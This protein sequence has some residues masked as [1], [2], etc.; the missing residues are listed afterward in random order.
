[1]YL[2]QTVAPINE[3]VSL[4]EAK[5]FMRILEN[6]DDTLIE[7]M[8]IGAR[9]YAE[10]YTNRQLMTAT[11]ELYLSDFIQDFKMPKNPIQSI[12]SIEYMDEDGNY[13]VLDSSLYY[14]YGDNDISKIHFEDFEDHKEHKKAIKITFVAGYTTVPSSI[15][16]YI[17]VLVSTMYE[18]R[19]QYIIGVSAETNANPMINK[20][21]DMYRVQPI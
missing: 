13:Q 7:S 9:E 17:K 5:K 8:I 18:N 2:V 14:L 10:N 19:E 20:L 15:I 16:A 4:D 21:L 6:D 3:P 1:M 12:T 11:Y